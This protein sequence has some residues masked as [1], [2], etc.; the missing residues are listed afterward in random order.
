ML[1]VQLLLGSFTLVYS[2]H[3]FACSLQ[4]VA[5]CSIFNIALKFESF[6]EEMKGA[7]GAGWD[8]MPSVGLW[9]RGKRKEIMVW[10]RN[11]SL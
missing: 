5:F 7:M 9:C 8:K 2:G 4:Q 1:R 3:G 11:A 6:N 10:Q